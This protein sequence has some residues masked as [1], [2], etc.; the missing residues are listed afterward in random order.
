MAERIL[1]IGQGI[2]CASP[3]A[4]VMVFI[5][6]TNLLNRLREHGLR[7]TNLP[8][9]LETV[10]HGRTLVRAYFYCVEQKVEKAKGVHGAEFLA[11]TRVVYGETVTAPDG[12]REKGVDA[13]L[14]ADLVYHA[15]ARNCDYA[16]L[17]THDTDFRHAIRRVEDFGCK[18]AVCALCEDAPK[19]LQEACDRYIHWPDDRLINWKFAEKTE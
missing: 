7:L 13:L 3:S 5:D 17:M 19:R 18:S 1:T 6:G 15:A 11:G 12:S 2:G 9:L 10:T 8:G 14:V 4:R 16:V